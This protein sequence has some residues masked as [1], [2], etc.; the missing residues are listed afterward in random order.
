MNN[1][2]NNEKVFLTGGTGLL[3]SSIVAELIANGY[4]ITALV[5]SPARGQKLLDSRVKL[6]EGSLH[7]VEKFAEQLKGQSGERYLIG[8]RKYEYS[9]IFAALADVTGNPVLTKTI[10]PGRMMMS[11]I[12]T[13]LSKIQGKQSPLKPDIVKRIQKNFWYSSKKAETELGVKFRPL[14]ETLTDTISW[15]KQNRYV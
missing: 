6:V 4:Q 7:E 11:R 2:N 14:S 8:G 5:R 9:E 1:N 3:G 12:V 13:L 15:F 10:T